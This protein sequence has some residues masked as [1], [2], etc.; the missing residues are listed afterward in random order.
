MVIGVKGQRFEDELDINA[1]GKG[2]LAFVHVVTR[3]QLAAGQMIRD[4][5]SPWF[6][7]PSYYQRNNVAVAPAIGNVEQVPQS[8]MGYQP[9]ETLF[10]HPSRVVRLMGL[11]YPDIGAGGGCLGR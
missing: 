3:W 5:T 6:G 9:G 1:V 2:D 8:S 10:I 11:D 4:I 7:E